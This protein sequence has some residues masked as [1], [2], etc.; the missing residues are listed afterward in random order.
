[1]NKLL[2]FTNCDIIIEKRHNG[3]QP[4]IFI[5]D[6]KNKIH[7]VCITPE[8]DFDMTDEGIDGTRYHFESDKVIWVG[9]EWNKQ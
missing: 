8:Y 9:K 2:S 6:S 4:A 3:K 7:M 1:M 5:K